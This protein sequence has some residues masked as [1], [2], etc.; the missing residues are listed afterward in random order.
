MVLQ[1]RDPGLLRAYRAIGEPIVRMTDEY[2][3]CA[4]REAP[5]VWSSMWG[6]LDFPRV[7]FGVLWRAART[8]V[9]IRYSCVLQ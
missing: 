7:K 8:G 1:A 6:S 9:R 4:R 3:G 2:I 5:W